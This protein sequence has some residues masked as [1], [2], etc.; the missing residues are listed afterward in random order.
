MNLLLEGLGDLCFYIEEDW[1]FREDCIKL[2]DMET[3]FL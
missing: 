1:S 2:D 3:D